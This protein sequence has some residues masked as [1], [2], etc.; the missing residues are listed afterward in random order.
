VWL[1]KQLSSDLLRWEE[2]KPEVQE[3]E[4]AFGNEIKVQ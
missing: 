3:L 1:E 4:L 2:D